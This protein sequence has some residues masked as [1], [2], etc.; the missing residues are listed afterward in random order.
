L[1]L[2]RLTWHA[3]V[4]VYAYGLFDDNVYPIYTVRVDDDVGAQLGYDAIPTSQRCAPLYSKT[5]LE[6][7]NH[8]IVF[9]LTNESPSDVKDLSFQGFM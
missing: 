4:A 9:T 1:G 8:T 6:M 2:V 7:G 3:S 5:G